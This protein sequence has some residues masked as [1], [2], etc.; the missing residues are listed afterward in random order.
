MA[1]NL[2]RN[3]FIEKKEQRVIFATCTFMIRQ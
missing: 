2:E 3:S 1:L